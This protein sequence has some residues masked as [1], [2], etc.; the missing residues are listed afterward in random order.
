MIIKYGIP[1]FLSKF[2]GEWFMTSC[3]WG[4]VTASS[5]SKL[6]VDLGA[7]WSW[8]LDV[9]PFTKW[10]RSLSLWYWKNATSLAGYGSSSVES[11][12]FA[13]FLGLSICQ[14]CSN[15][16]RD[17]QQS[18]AP[19]MNSP[20]FSGESMPFWGGRMIVGLLLLHVGAPHLPQEL[21][22]CSM[23]KIGRII[24][25]IILGKTKLE[26]K[27]HHPLYRKST[28]DGGF[29]TS[30][31]T[32]VYPM[33]NHH[34]TLRIINAWRTWDSLMDPLLHCWS[35]GPLA[36]KEFPSS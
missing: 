18:P 3:D 27:N 10:H 24:D 14:V 1:H 4:S 25:V 20:R 7:M 13:W 28:T 17:H 36:T 15:V 19:S 22:S 23:L 5:W 21:F 12:L 26:T 29:S 16:A 35:R 6:Y 2:D 11:W 33:S 8:S 31:L 34:L 32:R 30:R 9:P